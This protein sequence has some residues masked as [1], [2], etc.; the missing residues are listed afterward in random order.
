MLIWC[1]CWRGRMFPFKWLVACTDVDNPL[2]WSLELFICWVST[3][4]YSVCSNL[5][6]VEQSSYT[7]LL[8]QCWLNVVNVCDCWWLSVNVDLL[9]KTSMCNLLV[10]HCK[11]IVLNLVLGR[12]IAEQ[13]WFWFENQNARITNGMTRFAWQWRSNVTSTSRQY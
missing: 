2:G 9:V 12:I 7:F 13:Q 4:S 5:W 8:N 3:H 6:S 11:S 1:H 10:L